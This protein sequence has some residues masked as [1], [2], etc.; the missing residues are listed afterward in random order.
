MLRILFGNNLQLSGVFCVLQF[1]F[2]VAT[3][4]NEFNRNISRWPC[5]DYHV[6]HCNNYGGGNAAS[7]CHKGNRSTNYCNH[8]WQWLRDSVIFFFC[9]KSGVTMSRVVLL[10]DFYAMSLCSCLCIVMKNDWH[11]GHFSVMLENY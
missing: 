2:V 4:E 6:A 7:H 11:V 10:S 1:I 8:L 9:A 5:M 3:M